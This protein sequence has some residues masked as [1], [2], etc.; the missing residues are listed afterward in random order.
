MGLARPSL[1]CPAAERSNG[2]FHIPSDGDII[3][4]GDDQAMCWLV[5]PAKESNCAVIFLFFGSHVKRVLTRDSG[6]GS[7]LSCY[8]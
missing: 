7:L 3:T 8:S 4:V 2:Q 1:C 6:F 5:R